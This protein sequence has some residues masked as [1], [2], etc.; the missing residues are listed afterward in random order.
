MKIIQLMPELDLAGAEIMVENLTYFLTQAGHDVIV[1]SMYTKNTP[2]TRRLEAKGVRVVFLD[3]RNGLDLS[4]IFKMRD[5]FKSERPDIIHTHR[6]LACYAIPA[7]ILAGAKGRV[8]TVHNIA[9]RE[10]GLLYRWMY[11]F[12]YK[13]CM[14]HPVGISPSI[15]TTIINEY[16]LDSD[17]VDMVYNGIDLSKCVVKSDRNSDDVIKLLH[18]GRFNYQKN[19]EGIIRAFSI[20]CDKFPHTQLELW[21]AGELKEDCI[22][23]VDEL[24]L[25]GKVK[26]CGLT[27]DIYTVMSNADIFV[28]CSHYEGM[29][30][31]LIE[32]M[33]TGL[34]I[35]STAVGGVVDMIEDG[36]DG[37]LCEDS[38]SDIADK[39][40]K[41]ILD[42]YLRNNC[43]TN[44]KLKSKSYSVQNMGDEYLNIYNRIVTE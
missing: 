17:A 25:A 28:L 6:Y 20:V 35:L 3:K 40:M 23:L 7:A 19:H 15:K 38:V 33:A 13:Y 42:S 2:I 1:V 30:I 18:V 37:I 14:L 44:A 31:T 41:M 21:G 5:L 36:V 10:L 39:M 4:M 34:P 27:D 24:S 9:S 12:F 22:R 32:A 43:S 16:G 26:F 8:H 11:S 29:P